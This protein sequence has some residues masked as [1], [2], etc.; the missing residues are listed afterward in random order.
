MKIDREYV[1]GVKNEDHIEI[2]DEQF[3]KAW[4]DMNEEASAISQE[5]PTT[6][7][8]TTQARRLWGETSTEQRDNYYF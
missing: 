8:T 3:L 4:Y 6:T 7:A 2:K 1:S 5:D